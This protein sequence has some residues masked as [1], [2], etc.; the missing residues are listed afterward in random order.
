[1]RHKNVGHFDIGDFEVSSGKLAVSDPCYT[2]GTWCAGV[3]SNVK[4][5]TWESSVEISDEGSW[6]SRVKVLFA[7]LKDTNIDPW[8]KAKFVVGVDAGQVCI[9]DESHFAGGEG[10]Y[11]EP[12]T[13]YGD[14]CEKSS[15]EGNLG[16]GILKSGHGVNSS[17]GFGDGSYDCFYGTDK[18]GQIV[19]VKVVFIADEN[20]CENC[21]EWCEDYDM[22]DG[23]CPECRGL[24]RCNDCGEYGNK[25][26]NELCPQCTPD[27]D[28]EEADAV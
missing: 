28:E 4:N 20:E 17:S 8:T 21:G 14:A 10:E 5:G 18:D 25:V 27:E 19:S 24:A 1:M 13:F 2:A 23:E 3:L 6:G 11:G 9:V 15:G 7:H 12:E 16:A 26:E 22:V